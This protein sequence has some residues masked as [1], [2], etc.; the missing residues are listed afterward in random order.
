MHGEARVGVALTKCFYCGEDGDI[1]I[2]QRLTKHSAEKV[3]SMHGHVVSKEPCGTCAEHMKTGIIVITIDG[4]KS[5]GD[6]SN[7]YRMAESL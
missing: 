7:P 4:E 1:L 5:K 2:N 6:M 3:E